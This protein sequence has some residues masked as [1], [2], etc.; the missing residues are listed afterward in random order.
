MAVSKQ[1]GFVRLFF[2][3]I[4]AS[5]L[6][7]GGCATT[8]VEQSAKWEPKKPVKALFCYYS[9]ANDGGA[10][11]FDL[12]K[13]VAVGDKAFADI[14]M[15]TYKLVAKAL[16][17]Y[18]MSVST[19]RNRTKKLDSIA[20]KYKDLDTGNDTANKLL[21]TLTQQWSHPASSDIPFH[22]Y[23]NLNPKQLKGVV[24]KVKGSDKKE[25]FLSGELKIE[26]QDQF[27]VFKRFRLI[28]SIKGLDTSG[29]VVFQARAEG[30]SGLS[31][32]RNPMSESRIEKTMAKVLENLEKAKI[33]REISTFN[34]M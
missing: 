12:G 20:K 27:L 10:D 21:G 1:R 4:A 26:D 7:L 5:A 18:N 33:K 34:N 13:Q 6:L 22:R 30:F 25:I 3:A 17:K 9:V 15:G 29:N 16:E 31:F 32:L 11:L 23:A 2:A 14:G 8:W 28:L 19:S 24:D